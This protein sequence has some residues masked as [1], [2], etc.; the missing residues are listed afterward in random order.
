MASGRALRLTS[1]SGGDS[2]WA[3]NQGD[4]TI[5]R[6]DPTSNK[7][8]A[9]I[10]AVPEASVEKPKSTMAISA[11]GVCGYL[12]GS[13]QNLLPTPVIPPPH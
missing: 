11:S 10:P 12:L 5:T 1:W 13:S 3:L 9:N 8:A 4:G 7:V 6:I 2:V